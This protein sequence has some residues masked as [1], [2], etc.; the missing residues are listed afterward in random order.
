MPAAG[1]DADQVGAWPS[2]VSTAPGVAYAYLKDYRRNRR[3]IYH[4]AATLGGFLNLSG[5]S[6]NELVG[7]HRALFRVIGYRRIAGTPFATFGVP[8][9]PVNTIPGTSGGD[10]SVPE[11]AQR[12]GRWQAWTARRMVRWRTP[13]GSRWRPG[14]R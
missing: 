5:F 13:C 12:G 7:E 2:F 11:C 4:Q 14:R 3:D 8:A 1:S 10:C 9:K 6:R